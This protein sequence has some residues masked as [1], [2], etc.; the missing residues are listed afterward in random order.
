METIRR[1]ETDP[2]LR[3]LA[4]RVVDR[5]ETENGPA[6]VLAETLFF[7]EGG[8]QPWDLGAISGVPLAEVTEEDGRIFHLLAGASSLRPG[9]EA[10]LVLDWDRRFD[11]MQRHC[12]EHILSGIFFREFG[13]VNRGFHMGEDYMTI[14]I[15]LEKD[16][17]Y[18][19]VTWEMAMEAEL[20][21]NEAV[22]QNLPVSVRHFGTR[23]EAAGV[24]LR[25]DLEI[26][27]D[28]RI[29]CVGSEENPQDCVACCGTHPAASGEVGL[30]KIYKVES[31]KGMYRIYFEA[32]K[33]ALMDCRRKHDL[34]AALGARYSAG[35]SDL[36]AKLAAR[37]Q[38]AADVREGF[39]RLRQSVMKARMEEILDSPQTG[40]LT[41]RSYGD[42][43]QDD[44][45]AMG[46][47]ISAKRPGLLVLWELDSHTLFLFSG[48][49]PDCGKLV[50]DH[51]DIY[52]AKGGG[53]NVSSRIIFNKGENAGMFIDLLE[54]H[55]R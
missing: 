19:K 37:D 35:P 41:A 25:K 44:L 26:Q 51:L 53:N 31:Y 13:G 23:E 8:G 10:D 5:V 9:D 20:L 50:R 38:K 22:W 28:I 29:V 43:P 18:D 17:A 27:E 14:D 4:T 30:V 52:P 48:G 45:L 36:E 24:P 39:Y 49:K 1:Y 21:A 12:G 40:P 46:R 3:A 11:H 7:P 6:L 33:R 54:K 47:V 55:L 15:R 42:L 2:Y 16:P 32:G 34:V